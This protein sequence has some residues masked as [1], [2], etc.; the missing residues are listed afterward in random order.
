MQL[1]YFNKD[2]KYG[3]TG[4]TSN[5]T[6]EKCLIFRYCSKSLILIIGPLA[7]FTMTTPFLVIAIFFLLNKFFVF[8][9]YGV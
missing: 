5:A 4:I 1:L 2:P 7:V 9:V 6:N 8:F 3:S